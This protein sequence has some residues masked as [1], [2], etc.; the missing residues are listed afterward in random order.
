MIVQRI[1]TLLNRRRVAAEL[2]VTFRRSATFAL[3]TTIRLGHHDA[4]LNLPTENGV[5]TAFI[6]LLLD[7]C[8]GCKTL[9]D[10]R[11]SVNTILDIGGNVGLFGLA[12][13]R[14]FPKARIH[15]YEPNRLLQPYLS[16]QAQAG[17]FDIFL[18][19][20]GLE[21]GTISLELNED[22]VQ[23][24]SKQ[25]AGGEIPQI[26]LAEAI[27]RIGGE[28]D[29]LKMDCEGAEWEMFKDYSSWRRVRN[30]AMEY[31]LFAPEHTSERVKKTIA[32]F[33]FHLTSFRHLGKFGLLT[34]S[35][36]D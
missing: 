18:E 13:R 25:D 3:P 28:V 35:R 24:R 16:V 8:Y 4:L 32:D 17:A 12:A 7:D 36:S 6:D 11:A 29:F 31:H 2:G 9:R 26:A 14:M 30:L 33:G 23:T 5:K 19:A 20:V 10:R 15:C 22:S 21:P 34:A 27:A 1:S